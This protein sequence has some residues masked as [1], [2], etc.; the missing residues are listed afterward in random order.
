MDTTRND[1]LIRVEE[2]WVP[3][4][5]A[6][7]DPD[8]VFRDHENDIALLSEGNDRADVG[9]QVLFPSAMGE[10][11]NEPA[12]LTQ[13]PS[14]YRSRVALR[15]GWW[16][17]ITE[18]SPT[19]VGEYQSLDSAPFYDLDSLHSDGVRTIDLFATGLN[20]EDSQAGLDYFGPWLSAHTDFQR[21]LRRRDHDPLSNF[22]ALQSGEELVSE[23]LNVGEDYA[24]RIQNLKVNFK[25]RLTKNTKFRVN[26][27]MLRKKGERQVNTVQHGAAVGQGNFDCQACH[28]RSQR[29]QID[30]LTLRV[31]PAVEAKIGPIRAEYSR[32]MRFFSQNDQIVTANYGDFHI[33]GFGEET[34]AVVPETY[35][36]FDRLKLSA[37]LTHNTRFYANLKRGETKNRL[38]QTR[39]KYQGFDLR[40]TNETWDGLTLTGYATLQEQRNQDLPFFLPEEETA[41]A[42][43]T[44]LV[45]PYGIRRPIDYFRRT[46]GTEA[47]WRPF[48]YGS[49]L[50]GFSLTAGWEQGAINRRF[51]EYVIQDLDNPPGTVVDEDYSLYSSFHARSSLRWS[52][53]LNTYVRYRLRATED[54]LFAVNRYEGYTNTSLPTLENLV[55]IGGTLVLASNFLAM[56]TAGFDNRQHH[57]DVAHFEEDNYPMTFTLSYAPTPE[58]SLSA[59]YGIYSNW[60]DQDITFPSDDPVSVGDTQLW[61]YGGRGRVLSLGGSYAWAPRLTF[62][63]AT[64]LVWTRDAFDPLAD[65]PDLPSYSEVNVNRTRVTGGVD[66]LVRERISTY[67]RYVYED[68]EDKTQA[69]NSG[70]A[71]MF[72]SGFS[73]VY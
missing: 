31:E 44:A 4:P 6:F 52:P 29:Q 26:F 9:P 1:G 48:R 68:Y 66:W 53:N 21:Y 41:L 72:L 13:R 58:W 27:H 55:E 17:T 70:T 60:I 54:P 24:T 37:D 73:G 56:A 14:P 35:S 32:P 22:A 64:Q 33:Y 62:S 30:W 47:N 59:G 3:E 5:T 7:S 61:N 2:R 63:G 11:S 67:L 18:G 25:G 49:T 71:H 34:Y 42:V 45:P 50:R 28:V 69:F 57:S 19:K 38:R 40:L 36:Q 39:R 20:N 51:A 16:N 8:S 46:M 43:P 10:L 23:D 15:F 65:W 12:F